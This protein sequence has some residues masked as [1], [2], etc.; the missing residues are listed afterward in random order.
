M[1]G[2][3]FWNLCPVTSRHGY[4]AVVKNAQG[5]LIAVCKKCYVPAKGRENL[6]EVAK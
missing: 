4:L 1:N 5:G 6:A 3:A 2:N